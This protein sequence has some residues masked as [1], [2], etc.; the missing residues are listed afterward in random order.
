MKNKIKFIYI[1][2][3]YFP[4]IDKYITGFDIYIYKNKLL[5]LIINKIRISRKY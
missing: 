2:L 1:K 5:K 4:K 3:V